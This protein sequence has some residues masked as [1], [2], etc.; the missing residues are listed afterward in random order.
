MALQWF[1]RAG[2][3]SIQSLVTR[4]NYR[5]A[6]EQLKEALQKR[7]DSEGLRI[8][9]ADVLVLA[10]RS[11]EAVDLL[12]PLADDLALQ[13]RPAKAIA[14]LKRILKIQPRDPD[15]VEKLAY[16]IRQQESPSPDPWRTAA[17]PAPREDKSCG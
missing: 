5:K 15:V 12:T 1:D 8:Q 2:K 7:R 9:L 10:G 14:V 6:I 11:Q 4:R 3:D 13:G 17:A 16:F